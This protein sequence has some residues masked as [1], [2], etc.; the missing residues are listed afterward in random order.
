MAG[1]FLPVADVN[2]RGAALYPR[3]DR[4]PVG[5][6]T[7]TPILRTLSAAVGAGDP[8][9]D[10][11]L[12]RRFA[13]AA[14]GTA[15]EL[16][17][18]RHA[19]TVWAVCRAALPRDR[20]A[21]EDAFQATFLALARKAGSVR[22]PSAAGWL[23]RVARNA[24]T[25]ARASGRRQPAGGIEDHRPADAG[26]SPPDRAV[27]DE[28]AAVVQDE[29]D[30]L[31]AKYRDPVV[32]CFY[33]GHS[34]AEA[35][36][37]LGWPVGTVASRLA[38]A[39]DRLRDRLT[40]RG[41]ALPAGGLAV[42]PATRA[43]AALVR[44]TVTTVLGP[45]GK[46]PAGVL[47][48]TN[49]VMSAMRIAK[50]KVLAAG[51]AAAVVLAAGVFAAQGGA[52]PGRGGGGGGRSAARSDPPGFVD[53]LHAL[54]DH[55]YRLFFGARADDNEAAEKALKA[56]EGVWR[57]KKIVLGDRELPAETFATVRYT[58]NGDTIEVTDEFAE[59][60]TVLKLVVS[61]GVTPKR[62]DTTMVKVGKNKKVLDDGEA[63]ALKDKT[64]PG[65]Y[66]LDGDTLTVCARDVRKL[67]DGPPKELKA[68][69]WVGLTVFERVK[70]PAELAAAE[71]KTLEGAWRAVRADGGGQPRD[72]D[73]LARMRVRVL[74]DR[75]H[76]YADGR[77]EDRVVVHRIAV[78]PT[79]APRRIDLA[80]VAW[81]EKITPDP[82]DGGRP[83]AGIYKLDGDTLTICAA[84][85]AG[86]GQP[87]PAA[88]PAEFKGGKD[89]ALLVLE[90]V[91]DE[92]EELKA[93]AGEWR[94]TGLSHSG[95]DAPAADVEK[96]RWVIADEGGAVAM[97][98][99]PG[100]PIRGAQLAVAPAEAP[101]HVTL[102]LTTGPEVGNTLD[103]IYFRQGD[104]LV[105]A[106]ADPKKKGSTRP[107]ELKPG[108]GVV[109]ITLERKKG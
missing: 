87:P 94:F 16:L 64:I 29:V 27:G 90:R 66:K 85:A 23:F 70:D 6:M 72:P 83:V 2:R 3:R 39:K 57:V 32:L 63:Q 4:D 55:L 79:T 48:L 28:T 52:G 18:R 88:R 40:R 75:L 21:A 106:F 105:A 99:G 93:L 41:V 47:A 69:E 65:I 11:E 46:V 14:D 51:S 36:A 81:G 109:Y 15:F 76:L 45:A 92:K 42:L 54:H 98:D 43:D 97:S 53:H 62:F 12:L 37:R 103:G 7:D 101:A 22:G 104:K 78:T 60:P 102:T 73:D 67:E 13:H 20:H 35:A 56:L 100:R 74:G 91:K 24:A 108:D 96:M 82:A 19:G 61:P 33:Q 95:K 59:E 50:L 25:R 10:A 17:V 8:A 49:G 77:D 30:R 58:I 31:A 9:P 26:R 80:R 71:L 34:H 86:P 44:H 1:L 107:K 5:P 68:G 84:V 38:R 89:L